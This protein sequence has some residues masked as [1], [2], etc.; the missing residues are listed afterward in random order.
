MIAG[1]KQLPRL[2]GKTILVAATTLLLVCVALFAY[3]SNFIFLGIPFGIAGAL[4][5]ILD[6]KSFF[7]FFIFTIPLSCDISLGPLSTTVPDEQF[8]W[9]FVL[10]TALVLAYNRKRLPERFLRHPLTLVFFLQYI[11]LIV[12]VCFSTDLI[13]SLKF[14]AA[15]TWFLSAYVIMPAMILRTKADIRKMFLLFAVPTLLHALFAFTWHWTMHFDFWGSNLVVKP[16]YYNHVDY[17][18]IISMIFPMVLAAFQLSKGRKKFRILWLCAAIFLVPAIFYAGARAAMLGVIFSLGIAFAIRKKLVNLV[19]P[20]FFL[21]AATMVFYL[22]Q[23]ETY[24][25]YRPNMK[26]T[27]TQRTF[28][29][30]ITATF[31]GTDMSSMERFYRWIASARMSRE[32]PLTGVGPNNFYAN[33]KSYTSPMFKTWVSRNPEKSTTHS[34]FLFMLVEQGW[35]AML[36][37]ALLVIVVFARAQRLYHQTRDPFH[38]SAVMALAMTFAVGFVNNCFSELIETHKV[39][40]LFYLSLSLLILL[41]HKIQ[42][43]SKTSLP[44]HD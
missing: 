34:Y 23:N 38:K 32:R 42:Q 14:L 20:A 27:A 40:A 11:W 9:L 21:F 12:A 39:G 4:W 13:P 18:T 28:G 6:W 10:L 15:K 17:S 2:A 16:F 22:V 37:Y 44:V 33:Y 7:W 36:L 1:I 19:M 31:R 25:K 29:D 41:D 26:Y 30:L 5:L 35:P 43:E 3:T 24:V 8:M